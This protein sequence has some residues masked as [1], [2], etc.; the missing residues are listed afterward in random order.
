MGVVKVYFKVWVYSGC[1]GCSLNT[2]PSTLAAD[3]TVTHPYP[4]LQLVIGVALIFLGR[5]NVSRDHHAQKADILNNWVVLGVF[6]ITVINVFISS[7]SIEPFR[8]VDPVLLRSV[9]DGKVNLSPAKVTERVIDAAG[10]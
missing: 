4:S 1:Y 5:Y 2:Y 3:H 8:G 10:F 9:M 6:I 7:F